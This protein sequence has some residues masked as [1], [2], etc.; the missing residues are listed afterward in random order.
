LILQVFEVGPQI[1][2]EI[3]GGVDKRHDLITKV[4]RGLL[5]T[6]KIKRSGSGKRGDPFRYEKDSL[7]LS[8]VYMGEGGREIKSGDNLKESLRNSPP[9]DFPQNG[10]VG[11]G[12]EK[13]FLGE[14]RKEM[15][16]PKGGLFEVM[17]DGQ[18]I[19]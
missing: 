8:P 11:E 19:Y 18:L 16:P 15:T 14:K 12:M 4:I 17:D 2:N 7:L 9:H 3:L 1:M 6:G 13:A 5:E 10:E